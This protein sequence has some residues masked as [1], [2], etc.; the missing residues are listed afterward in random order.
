ME[1]SPS[2]H[3][4]E[5]MLI[6]RPSTMQDGADTRPQVPESAPVIMS[7]TPRQGAQYATNS[8]HS[9]SSSSGKKTPIVPASS[10][11]ATDN[12][13]PSTPI[14]A[15]TATHVS[16]ED[17]SSGEELSP[18]AENEE[19]TNELSL[20][21]VA[22]INVLVQNLTV[23]IDLERSGLGAL[24]LPFSK[25][26]NPDPSKPTT[27]KILDDVSARMPSGSLTA[28][29]GASGSGKTS[30][31]NVM[32][33]RISDSRLKQSGKTLYN[34][35]RNLASIRSAYVMQQDV[36][37]P[38][39]TVRETLQYSADLR[40]PPPTTADERHFIVEEVILELGLKECA[41]TRIGNNEH[42]GCSG[43]E[44]RRT[45]LA[46][47]LLANPS[48]LFCDEVT[49]GL[50]AASAFQLVKTLKQLARKGRTVIITIHQPRSEIW[51]LFDHLVLLTRG[52]PV[53]SGPAQPCLEYFAKLGHELPPFVN[54]AEHLIDLAAIDTRSPEL[55][56]TSL[57]RVTRLKEAW[58]ATSSSALSSEMSEKALLQED[59]ERTPLA[60][61][62]RSPF[63]RQV[64]VQTLRTIKTT[65]RDPM[66]MTGSLVEVLGMSIITGW[67]FLHLD[68]SL[69]GIRSREGALYTAGSLQG[70]LIL[71]FE[72]YRLTLDIGVF[73]REYSEGVVSVSSWLLSR[74]LARLFLEDIPI[75]LI[76]S[77]IFY[78]MVGFRHNASQFFIFFAIELL[79]HYLAVTLATLAVAISRDFTGAVL[80]ANMNF[81]L[82][83]MCSGFFVQSNQ[84]PIWYTAYVWYAN[85][86]LS[87]NEF[88][89]HTS[90]PYGQF[91][92]CPEPGGPSNPACLEYTG[93]FI[94]AALGY[95]DNW[96]WRPIVILT[97]FVF[98]FLIGSGVVLRYWKVEMSISKARTSEEDTSVG[99]EQI[100]SRSL[101]EVRTI[102]IELNSLTLNIQKYEPWGRKAARI[103]ILQP[104][105]T[106]FEPGTLNVIMGPSGSGKTSLLNLMASR[107]Y[108][109]FGTRY[110]VGGTMMYGG[111]IPSEDVIRS[112]ASYVCQ[113]DDALLA[114]LT[115]RETLHFAAGLR[116]P[117]WMSKAEKKRRAEEVLVKLG[118]RDCANNLV[119]NDLIKGISG[120]EKR[121][122]T[123]A[124][125]VLTDPRILL[126]D[127][128]TSGLDA[129]TASSIIEVLRGLAEEGRT[130]V[131][132]IH[133]SR[134]DLWNHFGNVLLLARGGSPVYAGK[135]RTMLEHFSFL[136]YDCPKTTNPADFALDLITV[137]LQHATREARSRAKVT[138]L[139]SDW[140]NVRRSQLVKTPSHISAPA[141][142][143]SLKRAMTPF[144]IAFPLLVQRSMIGF[145]RDPNAIL[146]RTMQVIGFA[147]IVTLFFAP[148]KSDYE[149]VQSRLGFIQEFAA[150]YFVGMLQ[151]VAV[152]PIEKSVFYREHDD[153]AY[154]IEAFFLQYTVLE[155]PFEILACLAFSAISVFGA[156]LPRTAQLFLIVAFNAFCVVNCGESLGIMFNTLFNHTGFAVNL[157]SVVLS[158]ATLM[159]GVISLNI[160]PF[161]QA[162]NHLSPSKW[163]LGNLAP[164]SL[165]G[166][167]FSCTD[168]QRLPSGACP[169][170]TGQQALQLYNLDGNARINLMALGV[171]TVGYRVVA[172]LL[173]KAKRTHW[174]WKERFRKTSSA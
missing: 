66:G 145:R 62:G 34:G 174:G 6:Q 33:Q 170:A 42:K 20:R 115:V 125:Q 40:L 103:S 91:Y 88:L 69:T 46:V 13:A 102:G 144:R 92:D 81:T 71:L 119:G 18:K 28:I 136:G 169:I 21:A 45:S 148:L 79:G 118:L 132:T 73:D 113:D 141:E 154:S 131:L 19:E 93:T 76:F 48:V 143:G 157:T 98:A 56:E 165:D 104:I 161:L 29:I 160:S 70:Y 114:T 128:P 63:R 96:L 43:G 1:G 59:S 67:I 105:S 152:Y 39:L 3:D 126:L 146:A 97:A 122:V 37:L 171:V 31:L 86:A 120:G 25:R 2:N 112:V 124:I 38:T 55:E 61:G 51:G 140:E 129:F 9:V 27:K 15:S 117:T 16:R 52:S 99:K 4:G 153:R 95:P 24:R 151:N 147:I 139:I 106:N 60:N 163:A 72:T 116:L 149:S 78:F 100:R 57:A 164:Y 68:G 111:S 53:Y 123:I 155:V 150:I 162:F 22:P 47:Q 156:G 74:R 166:I 44:K 158:V 134:S 64:K 14:V 5:D 94:F 65:W 80:I 89:S 107:L 82:Q 7:E 11:D 101:E 159:A 142:L 50:D 12:E 23:A 84:I 108:S 127:E 17:M 168:A 130:L 77:I 41:N 85:G 90:S 58:R 26:K 121:R 109:T 83:S 30:M 110:E 167:T 32:S 173:L 35:N 137:D 49:T 54:P 8:M 135:G 36:L 133:Q 172:Y 75:P 87:A 10:Q 138:S